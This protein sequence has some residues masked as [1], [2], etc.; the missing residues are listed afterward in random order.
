MR[1]LTVSEFLQ[2]INDVLSGVPALIEGEVLGFVI[3]QERWVFF[4]LKDASGIVDCFM[5]VWKLRH[6]VAD[7]MLVRIAGV[8]GIYAKAGRFRITVEALEPV[9]EGSLRRAFELLKQKLEQEGVF[10]ATRKRPIPRF[11][12]RIGLIASSESA[13]YTDFVRI[14]KNRWG[15]VEILLQDVAVQGVNAIDDVCGAFRWW[16]AAR[17]D[18]P[19]VLVLVRG[20]GSLEDLQAFNAEAVARAIFASPIPVVVGVGHE[21]DIT[22]ADLVADLRAST[23]S[24]AAELVVPDR[25]EIAAAIGGCSEGMAM[26]LRMRVA[27]CRSAV[28][29]FLFH[30]TA[31]A[32]ARLARI[33]ALAHGIVHRARL[34]MMEA[35][36]RIDGA[37]RLLENLNPLRMLARGYSLTWVRG[38]LL[39]SADAVAP[40]D[41]VH[42]R[43][44]DGEI[45]AV[46]Q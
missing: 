39:R 30:G 7:G 20:G 13:A 25:R 40:G 3:R 28:D 11:P 14:L 36:A 44:R 37:E 43:F 33:D 8:P 22:I 1:H 16:H 41:V 18:H 19:E 17:G 38:R 24:N 27:R 42:T 34:R 4:S 9:G 10:A 45:D 26:A 15:D 6:E 21:R 12:S 46:V 31:F 5:P 2:G 35:R 23:P 32:H 29:R